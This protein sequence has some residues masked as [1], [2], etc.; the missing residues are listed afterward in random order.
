VLVAVRVIKRIAK[1]KGR[2]RDNKP[3]SSRSRSGSG[4]QPLPPGGTL[5][6]KPVASP[7]GGFTPQEPLTAWVAALQVRKELMAQRDSP[8]ASSTGSSSPFEESAGASAGGSNPPPLPNPVPLPPR[9]KLVKPQPL[10]GSGR[11][12][13]AP[14]GDSQSSEPD[15]PTTDNTALARTLDQA[16]ATVRPALEALASVLEAQGSHPEPALVTARAALETFAEASREAEGLLSSS[17]NQHHVQ[18]QQQPGKRQGPGRLKI[19]LAA[20]ERTARVGNGHAHSHSHAHS[21]GDRDDNRPESRWHTPRVD[22]SQQAL[23]DKAA[24]LA[25][26]AGGLNAA[27]GQLRDT[28][29]ETLNAI[30]FEMVTFASLVHRSLACQ[31]GMSTSA[32]APGRQHA[33]GRAAGGAV[34]PAAVS[35]QIPRMVSLCR[36]VERGNGLGQ[37]LSQDGQGGVRVMD[38]TV[39]ELRMSQRAYRFQFDRVVHSMVTEGSAFED[40]WRRRGEVDERLLFDAIKRPLVA[41]VESAGVFC[42]LSCGSSAAG[43]SSVLEG[44]VGGRGLISRCVDHLFRA[45]DGQVSHHHSKTGSRVGPSPHTRADALQKADGARVDMSITAVEVRP[46]RKHIKVYHPQVSD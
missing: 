7:T 42:F 13:L 24:V 30:S 28:V 31:A 43:K 4:G 20:I 46:L 17:Q 33:G 16:R 3:R 8:M 10:N 23:R 21:F 34:S 15:A 32:A 9:P 45:F 40:T 11:R 6:L 22:S 38:G 18:Q 37:P 14:L 27:H 25:T 2:D 44:L 26:L 19:D 5:P 35:T 12:V 36:V 29:V 41:A 1:G 39:V